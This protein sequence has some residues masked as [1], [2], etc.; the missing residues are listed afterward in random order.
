MT[1]VESVDLHCSTPHPSAMIPSGKASRNYSAA[2][3][4]RRME[5]ATSALIAFITEGEKNPH[6][7]RSE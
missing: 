2:C 3:E 6:K 1:S 5:H 4:V 7:E